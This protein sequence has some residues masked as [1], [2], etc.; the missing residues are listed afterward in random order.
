[1]ICGHITRNSD[2]SITYATTHFFQI[3]KNGNKQIATTTVP[4]CCFSC[5]HFEDAESG[6]FGD[7][8]TLPEC[9]IGLVLPLKSNI[10]SCKQR[11]RGI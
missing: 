10:C 9:G 11:K 5:R 7:L 6:E 8:L 1:M 3:D 4:E 2:K